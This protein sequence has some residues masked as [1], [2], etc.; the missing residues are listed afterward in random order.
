MHNIHNMN[1]ISHLTG[2]LDY[3]TVYSRDSEINTRGLNS[4][5]SAKK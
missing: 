1:K 2:P 3:F 4:N 5:K